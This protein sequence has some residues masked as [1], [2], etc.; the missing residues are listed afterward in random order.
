VDRLR[1]LEEEVEKLKASVSELQN[2]VAALCEAMATSR[3]PV[4]LLLWQRGLPV[5][6]QG[7]RSQTLLPPNASPAHVEHFYRLLRRYS[8]RLFLRDLIQFP[9]GAD[10]NRLI[11]YCSLTSARSYLKELAA[12]GVV[13]YGKSRNYRLLPQRISSFGATLEWYVNEILQREFMAPALFNVRLRLTH[14]G[15]DYDVITI[16][17]GNLV[18]VE[19][20]SSPPRGV[21]LQAVSA[22]LHRLRDLQPHMAIFLVDTELRMKDK[23]VPLFAE[24]LAANAH[25]TKVYPIS[26][27]INEIFHI[28]HAIYLVNSRNGIYTNLRTCFRDFLQKGKKVGEMTLA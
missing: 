28:Q 12:L 9:E 18:Y 7:D 16:V 5:M 15:G 20:K 19:I 23:I 26:R 13:E 8:F 3:H 25:R 2:Q 6:A 14:Y 1:R 17:N 11:R 10:Q 24:A 4:E 27:L 21:E 22:F